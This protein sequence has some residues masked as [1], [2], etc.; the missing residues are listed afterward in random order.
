MIIVD[1]TILILLKPAPTLEKVS[2]M[3]SRN[4]R[5][6]YITSTLITIHKWSYQQVIFQINQRDLHQILS[7]QHSFNLQVK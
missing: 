4:Q 7:T 2:K 5:R 3:I 6:Q 1:V